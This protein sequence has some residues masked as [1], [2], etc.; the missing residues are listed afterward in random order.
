M[1]IVSGFKQHFSKSLMPVV[2]VIVVALLVFSGILVSKNR[3][4]SR[5]LD[6]IKPGAYIANWYAYSGAV[7]G[8]NGK[9]A[10]KAE[11]PFVLV[12]KVPFAGS[13][14]SPGI[15]FQKENRSSLD[16]LL[17]IDGLRKHLQALPTWRK[18]NEMPYGKERF[19]FY[20]LHIQTPLLS[21]GK[22]KV[23]RLLIHTKDGTYAYP[24]NWIVEVKE[25]QKAQCAAVTGQSTLTGD[26]AIG[27]DIRIKNTCKSPL[28][29]EGMDVSFPDAGISTKITGSGNI[30]GKE[31]LPEA[32]WNKPKPAAQNASPV[33]PTLL[34]GHAGWFHFALY[35]QN[36]SKVPEFVWLDTFVK[37]SANGKVFYAKT[38]SPIIFSVFP[39]TPQDTAELIKKEFLIGAHEE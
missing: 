39:L 23:E 29:V 25:K 12:E 38:Y 31:P 5:S 21:T 16:Y 19:V 28:K 27:F 24:L 22:H 34:P 9:Q 36:G 32:N 35:L 37:C 33:N 7:S 17:V 11:I 15:V 3:A 30:S 14:N 26:P 6:Y 8:K 4:N 2:V 13:K 10:V 18:G 20:T 1:E